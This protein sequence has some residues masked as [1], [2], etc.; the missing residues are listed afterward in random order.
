MIRTADEKNAIRLHAWGDKSAD[1][2]RTLVKVLEQLPCG[3]PPEV[4]WGAGIAEPTHIGRADPD[5][6]PEAKLDPVYP[7]RVFVSYS[8]EPAAQEFV[9]GLVPALR[10]VGWEVIWDADGL[11]KGEQISRFCE[12]VRTTRYFLPVLTPS[13]LRKRWCLSEFISFFESCGSE[14][15]VFR[16]RAAA[17]VERDVIDDPLRN[18]TEHAHGCERTFNEYLEQGGK[19]LADAVRT[20]VRKLIAG[21]VRLADLLEQFTDEYDG[22]GLADLRA[23][24]YRDVIAA[25]ERKYDATCRG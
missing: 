14:L 3:N 12:Q 13:Y 25:L 21:A 16:S 8:H 17:A 19:H 5:E 9:G 23:D 4:V 20:Q 2:L 18:A 22:R 10:A 6:K 11:Q 24:A 1:V 15:A 7:R